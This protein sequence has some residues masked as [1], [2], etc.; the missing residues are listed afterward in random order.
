L[1]DR[2][3]CKAEQNKEDM[4]AVKG[5]NCKIQMYHS[6]FARTG[7]TKPMWQ[8]KDTFALYRKLNKQSTLGVQMSSTNKPTN[9]SLRSPALLFK[10]VPYKGGNYGCGAPSLCF[11]NLGRFC[12]RYHDITISFD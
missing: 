11:A 7:E 8:K 5:N 2:S 4:R 6:V 3:N 10:D 12:L 1:H 9:S